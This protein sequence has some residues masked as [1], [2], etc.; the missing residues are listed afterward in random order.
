VARHDTIH[1]KTTNPLLH[2]A[3]RFIYLF[4]MLAEMMG[5]SAKRHWTVC[6]SIGLDKTGLQIWV[7]VFL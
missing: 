3:G 4:L 2:E 6:F 7:L 5:F 1:P